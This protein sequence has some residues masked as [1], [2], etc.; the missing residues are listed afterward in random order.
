MAENELEKKLKGF[1]KR[2]RFLFFKIKSKPIYEE[3]GGKLKQQGQTAPKAQLPAKVMQEAIKPVTQQ[4]TIKPEDKKRESEGK[5][6]AA[7]QTA[8][9]M[10]EIREGKIQ[11]V[12]KGGAAH[13]A[14]QTQQASAQQG[15]QTAAKPAE[16][17]RFGLFS[18]KEPK[19][20]KS[21]AIMQGN[22]QQAKPTVQKPVGQAAAKPAEAKK[23]AAARRNPAEK[24]QNKYVKNI[25]AHKRWLESALTDAD[26]KMSPYEFARVA[27]RNAAFAAAVVGIA[28][29]IA[30]YYLFINSSFGA[31]I[32]LLFGFVTAF[33]TYN[34]LLNR[35]LMY[36]LDKRKQEGKKVEKDIL[37]AARDLVISMRSGMPLFNAITAV[38][39]GYGEASREF[40]RIIELVEV[41]VPIEQAMD[42]VSENS[43]SKTF[44]RIILQASV[45]IRAGADVSGSLQGVVEEV[46]EE[47]VIELRRYG[48]RLNALAMFYM[49]FGVIF[50]SMGVAVAT[51]LTTFI[52]IFTINFSVLIAVLVGVIFMQVIFLNIM[53]T[54][55][56][57][58]AM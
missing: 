49:L 53:R 43:E 36:P 54:S 34:V 17:K 37:F 22:V 40:S 32:S 39:T 19:E 55:R 8:K 23:E 51:I 3:D 5:V 28:I 20:A 52:S 42:Q 21:A 47:R 46:Q 14:G 7:T 6:E 56:P 38:S 41:G 9:H 24:K 25:A 12:A 16:K 57:M 1:T 44:K 18:R 33:A 45:S 27:I 31:V 11:E 13:V 2:R 10:E 58:F 48:Q 35:F 15:K 26:I 50:P 4:A 30:F 29:T